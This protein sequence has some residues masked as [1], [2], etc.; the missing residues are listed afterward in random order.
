MALPS[1][2][3]FKQIILE[4]P[5]EQLVEEYLFDGEVYAFRELPEASSVLEKHLCSK[6]RLKSIDW[7]VVGSAKL[8]FSLAPD[9]FLQPFTDYSD[10]DVVVVNKGLFDTVWHSVLRWHYPRRGEDLPK[11]DG[12]WMRDRRQ[13]VYWGWFLPD[14]LHYPGIYRPSTLEPIGRLS[15]SWFAAFQSLSQFPEFSGRTFNG[16]LYRT[17]DFARLYHINGLRRIA[18]HLREA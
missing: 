5:L 15:T 12:D 8:G 1:A 13:N 14:E 2:D 16:R 3:E 18:E 10:S 6:L 9:K 4:R 17:W 11:P 7:A